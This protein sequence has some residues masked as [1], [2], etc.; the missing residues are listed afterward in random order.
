[1]TFA[2]LKIVLVGPLP[3]PAGGMATQTEQLARLLR[4]E[5]ADVAVV[6]ANA[7][8]RPR[9]IGGVRGVRALFRLVP[10][11][12]RLRH[13]LRGAD[14]CHVMAN[15]GWSW[16]LCAAPAIR[17]AHSRRVPTVVNY[18][19]GEAATFLAR[20]GESVARTLK[21][22]GAL[23]VPSRFLHEIFGRCGIPSEIVPNIVDL[24]RFRP[25]PSPADPADVR[26]VVTRN[27]EPMYDVPTALRA[28]ALVRAAM[29]TA[30][31]IVAGTGP[32]LPALVALSEKLGISAAV[33]FCGRLERD[34][35]AALYRSAAV[36]LNPSRVDNMPNSVLEAMAC[37]VPVVSTNVGGVPFVLR[38]G[39]TGL[40]V[41]AGDP[42]AMARAVQRLL[43][44][45]AL[46]AR[47]R[48]AA[49]EDVQQYGWA[50]VR[51]RWIDVYA[52]AHAG[53][54]VAANAA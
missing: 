31:L 29:P 37:G 2:G 50:S 8:Y 14:L 4:S 49:I 10:Y 26:L 5:G 18:R 23:V 27:L 41:D 48:A 24:D 46:A 22:A 12:A 54:R 19:G 15:S 51:Q 40:L 33:E 11:V 21:K 17:L 6:A 1:M 7:P 35:I 25:R 39:V 9:W 34:E 30:R 43:G 3:P 13:T 44:D 36:A 47:I 53:A 45:A 20:R 38:D 32:E 52:S 28:F 16:H 42:A